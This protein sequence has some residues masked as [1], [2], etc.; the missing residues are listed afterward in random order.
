MQKV[1]ITGLEVI[2][3]HG[4]LAEEKVN[5]QPFVFDATI[6]CDFSAAAVNDDL[7]LTVNYAEA[8][9][10]LADFCKENC[11]NLIETLACRSARLLLEK[12][13]VANRA[14]VT[15]HKPEA[16][17]G[18]PF[19]DVSVTVAAER[20]KALLSL[21]S[22]AGDR[23]QTLDGAL[24]ALDGVDGVKLLKVSKY[25]ETE[26]YGGAAKNMFLNCAA[27][28]ECLIS[29]RQLLDEIHKIEKGFGRVRTV[30]WGDR[31]LDIDIVFFGDKV[32]A[33]EGLCVPHPD[34][35]NRPFVLVPLKEIA[36][37]F[38]CPKTFKRI[39]DM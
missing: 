13:P 1:K 28:A 34:Y 12:F 21:G 23:K 38:A 16:P 4:V 14:E 10:A 37:D 15:V 33:E 22:S 25:I 32:I 24:S 30:R 31:T 26:P 9:R 8:C 3:R 17:I 7:S 20:N 27:V 19:K 36:P 35:L 6:D 2:A 18:L 29:P 11:F 5:A 39:A